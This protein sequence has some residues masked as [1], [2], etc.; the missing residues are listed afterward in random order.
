M[1]TPFIPRTHFPLPTTLPSYFLG[2]HAATL[3]RLKSLISTTDLTIECRDYR[4][5]LTSRNPLLESALST[6]PRLIVYMSKDLGIPPPASLSSR[7]RRALRDREDTVRAWTHPTPALFVDRH[8][9]QH[10]HA[11]LR[12][13]ADFASRRTDAL[14][15]TTTLIVGM[16]NVGKSTL[17]NALRRSGRMGTGRAKVARTGDQPGVT[18]KVGTPV[19]IV[20]GH[21]EER[22]SVYVLD[23]PGVFVPYVPDT[24]A[25]LRLALVGCVKEG[26][27]PA[28]TVADYALFRMNLEDP[29]IYAKYVGKEGPTNDVM[30]L[31]EGVAKRVGR[32]GR[33]GEANLESAAGWVVQQWRTGQ[34]GRFVLDDVTEEGMERQK[35]RELSAFP[36]MSQA[37]KV[38]RE[39]ARFK[40]RQQDLDVF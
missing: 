13:L 21:S 23:T 12:H 33:G 38:A 11:V 18:R 9:K 32:F 5:P 27:V 6:K 36:S 17:L 16:P 30:Q 39:A 37:K 8:N 10:I 28:V 14:T 24:E 35:E 25:M 3:T 7:Q 19:K 29:G 31:L 34:L 15:P 2:H 1:A 4:L 40:V 22:E 26:L 20:D